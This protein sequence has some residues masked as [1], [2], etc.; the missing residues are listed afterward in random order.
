M[1]KFAEFFKR[2]RD[3]ARNKAQ[4]QDIGYVRVSAFPCCEEA[5]EWAGGFKDFSRAR[6]TV[7]KPDTKYEYSL[8]VAPDG[9]RILTEQTRSHLR[10]TAPQTTYHPYLY[11]TGDED[12][13]MRPGT[14][15]VKIKEPET[16]AYWCKLYVCVSNADS[17]GDYERSVAT[18]PV[19]QEFFES[20][21]FKVEAHEL[22][23]E[24]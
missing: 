2:V 21:G 3:A 11:S 4:A 15:C 20:E 16:N 19:I 9:S 6:R 23:R 18:I 5:D 7:L 8:L 24:G 14:L 12:Y 17:E 13:A 22:P 10:S 1:E